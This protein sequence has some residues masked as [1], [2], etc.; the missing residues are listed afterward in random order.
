[1]S[2]VISTMHL[3]RACS[4]TA[5]RTRAL[6][7]FGLPHMGGIVGCLFSSVLINQPLTSALNAWYRAATYTADKAALVT[8]GDI[9]TVKLI[10]AKKLLGWY[11]KGGLQERLDME[12]FLKQYDELEDSIGKHSESL[13]PMGS[14]ND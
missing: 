10:F 13:G 7:A 4:H 11:G 1:M 8:I 6:A 2:V 12:E 3:R 9:E 14:T 5:C